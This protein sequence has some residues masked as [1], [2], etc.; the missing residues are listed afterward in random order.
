MRQRLM[1][2]SP[3]QGPIARQLTKLIPDLSPQLRDA[4]AYVLDHPE[5]VAVHTVRTVADNAGVHPN[6]IMRLA[7][8]LGFAGFKDFRLAFASHLQRDA[9]QFRGRA[10]KLQAAARD[11]HLG[12]LYNGFA[13]ATMNNL[14]SLYSDNRPDLIKQAADR[15]VNTRRAYVFGVGTAQAL[16]HNFWYVANMA[17]DH[18]LQ[19]PRQGNLPIDEISRARRGDVLLLFGFQPYRADILEALDAARTARI[20]IIAVTDQRTSP[21]ALA[22]NQVLITPVETPQFFTSLSA[23]YALMETLLG[24]MVADADRKAVKR[25][26]KFHQARFDAGIYIQPSQRISGGTG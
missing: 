26:E 11:D 21:I 24:F 12:Q 8:L 20:H 9:R 19:I 22:A 10:D 13:R 14:E 18:L 6:T 2:T 3:A 4:A 25:I 17:F 15:I 23:A 16:A 5:M 1:P 7:R